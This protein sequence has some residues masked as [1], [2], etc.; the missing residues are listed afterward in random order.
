M[1]SYSNLS[2]TL[3][4]SVAPSCPW[5]AGSL[6]CCQSTKWAQDSGCLS[7]WVYLWGVELWGF[8]GFLLSLFPSC[9]LISTKFAFLLPIL[10]LPLILHSFFLIFKG[11]LN[12]FHSFCSFSVRGF[13]WWIQRF[14]SDLQCSVH[15]MFSGTTVAAFHPPPALPPA[16]TGSHLWNCGEKTWKRLD[17]VF[18]S[19]YHKIDF[20]LKRLLWSREK[21]QT[22][23]KL[24]GKDLS[25]MSGL[26]YF[27]NVFFLILSSFA[28]G[29]EINGLI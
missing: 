25:E 4:K 18:W 29:G 26:F 16:V 19:I 14:V 22:Y 8:F 24:S 10:Y 1:E 3:S 6:L 17:Q 7:S 5:V 11:F 20:L 2:K 15:M 23:M 21:N 28:T 27:P 12:V 13:L 9:L